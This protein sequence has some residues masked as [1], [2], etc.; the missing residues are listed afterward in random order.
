MKR[1]P[2]GL[3]AV[4]ALTATAAA[5]PLDTAMGKALFARNWVAAPASTDASDGLGPL[6][7]ARSCNACHAGGGPARFETDNGRLKA[8]GLV[9]RSGDPD[10]RPHPLLGAQLQTEALPGLAA[11]ARIAVRLQG[12]GLVV[13]TRL[14]VPEDAVVLE[15]RIAPSLRGRGAIDRI[16]E[17]AILALADPSDRDGDGLSGRAN[18]IAD[19]G[20]RLVPGRFGSKATGASLML[21]TAT[22]AALDLGLSSPLVPRPHGDCTPEQADCLAH[23]TGRSTI[24]EDEEI[25]VDMVR[26]ITAYVA[27]LEPRQPDM[28]A[29]GFELFRDSGCGGCHVPQ[30]PDRDG[31]PVTIF[32]DLLLH[33]MG[34]AT[35]SELRDGSAL[36]GEWRTAPLIDLD[37]RQETRRYL[38]GGKAATIEEAIRTHGGE[39]APARDR[40]RQLDGRERQLL[41]DFLAQL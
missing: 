26:L 15:T 32:S 31:M 16:D 18:M 41:L 27:T 14:Q 40:F 20:G 28:A 36:P 33:D 3:A 25:S 21:Q 17:T 7:N 38:H 34:D 10:G 23:A 12:E 6:F 11:E 29:R 22:A 24:T 4:L 2:A 37:P 9:V 35:S 19:A 8:R 1:I 13:E 30:L 5:D 39:A